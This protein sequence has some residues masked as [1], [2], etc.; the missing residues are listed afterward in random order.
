MLYYRLTDIR[1]TA[2]L[3]G[4]NAIGSDAIFAIT[5]YINIIII[6]KSRPFVKVSGAI[7]YYYGYYCC[8]RPFFNTHPNDSMF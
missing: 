3:L 4:K 6:A 8:S 2:V 5:R 1:I 7:L